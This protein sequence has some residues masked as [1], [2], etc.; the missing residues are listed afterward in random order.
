VSIHNY[1]SRHISISGA[2]PGPIHRSPQVIVRRKDNPKQAG[3]I[4]M[5]PSEWSSKPVL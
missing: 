1:F 5:S 2:C 4:V 3:R